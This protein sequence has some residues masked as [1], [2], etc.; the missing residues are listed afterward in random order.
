[1]DRSNRRGNGM[2][3]AKQSQSFHSYHA[4]SNYISS[5][6]GKISVAPYR[7]D[8]LKSVE[9]TNESELTVVLYL[10][11]CFNQTCLYQ[12]SHTQW[13][14]T[15][16]RKFKV[17]PTSYGPS[18]LNCRWINQKTRPSWRRV[19]YTRDFFE[20]FTVCSRSSFH[21]RTRTGNPPDRSPP[22]R[23]YA[24]RRNSTGEAGHVPMR[25]KVFKSLKEK[26]ARAK[27][28]N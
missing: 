16:H 13:N 28:V 15:P 5:I 24:S 3:R 26:Y 12:N 19:T 11:R 20:M 21:S 1:M 18:T 25:Y 22:W 8:R 17:R 27:E 6:I 7:N 4:P 23:E 2:S 10:P 14:H 9:M